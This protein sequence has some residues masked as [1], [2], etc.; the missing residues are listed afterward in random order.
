MPVSELPEDYT[1]DSAPESEDASLEA[2][3]STR[4]DQNISAYSTKQALLITQVKLNDL[5]FPKTKT[6]LPVS[7]LQ[8]WNFLEK[9]CESVVL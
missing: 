6:Q 2:G 5:N 8:L 9:M 3:S 7:R 1:L 4:E